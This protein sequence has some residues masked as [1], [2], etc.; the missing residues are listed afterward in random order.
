VKNE[1]LRA[2]KVEALKLNDSTCLQ[3]ALPEQDMKYELS[4]N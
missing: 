3:L 2:N 4:A 1:F